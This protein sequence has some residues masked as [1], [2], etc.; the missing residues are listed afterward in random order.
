MEPEF[1]SIVS[2]GVLVIWCRLVGVARLSDDRFHVEVFHLLLEDLCVCGWM[3]LCC[4]RKAW[5]M[6]LETNG[7][8]M[9]PG[10]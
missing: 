1:L 6:G 9:M 8:V 4:R 7:S 3:N 5:I 2:S 10:F